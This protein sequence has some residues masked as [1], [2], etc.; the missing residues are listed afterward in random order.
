MLL[1]I[2][3]GTEKSAFVIYDG[4]VIHKK[5]IVNNKELLDEIYRLDSG[6]QV[7]HIE[8]VASYGMAVGKDVFTTV[9]W[10]GRFI[11]AA[12]NNAIPVQE[13]Y[14]KDVKMWHCQSMRAKDSNIRQALIDKY[15]DPGT[16]YDPNPI[17]NDSDIKMSKDIWSAF[18]IAT[19]FFENIEYEHKKLF[20]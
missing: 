4:N 3:P 20:G 10:I 2:D 17:Y 19:M 14:R 15:G 9:V 13:I 1:A 7:I 6:V 11:E 16:K 5:G 8:M 18:A 12:H